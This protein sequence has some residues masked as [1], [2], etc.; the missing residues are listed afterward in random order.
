MGLIQAAVGAVGGV[1]AD[2]WKDFYTVPDGLPS[3]AALF[4]AVP[5]GTNAGRGSNTK[6]SSNIIT[7]GSKI[8]VPEGYGLLLMQDGKIVGSSDLYNARVGKYGFLKISVPVWFYEEN[9]NTINFYTMEFVEDP[10]TDFFKIEFDIDDG[11]SRG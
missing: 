6:G 1:L 3:T 9:T 8:V 4:A 7:N 2:Q 5:Q 10:R 11:H